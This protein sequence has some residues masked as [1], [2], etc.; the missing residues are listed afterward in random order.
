M[1]R[2]AS[3]SD[4]VGVH[5]CE[6]TGVDD[7]RAVGDA[8][9]DSRESRRTEPVHAVGEGREGPRGVEAD[10]FRVGGVEEQVWWGGPRNSDGVLKPAAG[11]VGEA[12]RGFW[13]DDFDDGEDVVGA[14]A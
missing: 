8:D 1:R 5:S 6:R 12:E 3:L 7:G 14:A 10:D 11:A 13:S 2:S 4:V 9:N